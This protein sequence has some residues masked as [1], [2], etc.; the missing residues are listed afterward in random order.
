MVQVKNI[1]GGVVLSLAL[2]GCGWLPVSIEGNERY[3]FQ[4]AM[5]NQSRVA[6][7]PKGSM[8]RLCS[9]RKW[10]TRETRIIVQDGHW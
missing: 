6:E 5:L 8:Y 9:R 7:F 4:H 2:G 1:C 3:N 10:K